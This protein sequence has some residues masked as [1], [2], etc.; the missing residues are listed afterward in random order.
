MLWAKF[1][2]G[3]GQ[4]L[5]TL[6]YAL[7]HEEC[8]C[9][10][11]QNLNYDHG[12]VLDW[13]LLTVLHIYAFDFE[14]WLQGNLTIDPSNNIGMEWLLPNLVKW[15]RRGCTWPTDH[16]LSEEFQ[17]PMN[18]LLSLGW[19]VCFGVASLLHGV[20]C[21][22]KCSL[23]YWTCSCGPRNYQKAIAK[24]LTKRFWWGLFWTP[25]A[26]CSVLCTQSIAANM[27]YVTLPPA[28]THTCTHIITHSHSH[29]QCSEH[30]HSPSV[31]M[32]MDA[33]NGAASSSSL[34]RLRDVLRRSVMYYSSIGDKPQSHSQTSKPQPHFQTTKPFP[35][36]S[37]S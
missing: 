37:Q 22:F 3:G 30:A 33:I 35:D 27:C 14:C 1:G 21:D 19:L 26:R 18:K 34:P 11:L 2:G 32:S 9:R 20:I 10:R 13:E 17:K 31:M 15:S 8:H 4:G 23:Y 36:Q 29:T 5:L 12:Q 28:L 25:L 7:S 16:L 24:A 6:W